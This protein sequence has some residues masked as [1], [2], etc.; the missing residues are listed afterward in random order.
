MASA[1]EPKPRAIRIRMCPG[2]RVRIF[3]VPRSRRR[4]GPI[5]TATRH[6]RK[7]RRMSV[8]RPINLSRKTE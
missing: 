5:A 3:R 4:T 1:R 7:K 8:S 6:C 2:E